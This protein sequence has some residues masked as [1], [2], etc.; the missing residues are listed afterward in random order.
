MMGVGYIGLGSNP[1]EL[2]PEEGHKAVWLVKIEAFAE[3]HKNFNLSR[4]QWSL[5][6]V[7]SALF[8]QVYWRSENVPLIES[9]ALRQCPIGSNERTVRNALTTFPTSGLLPIS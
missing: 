9:S 5:K 4:R 1:F 7:A 3:V 6:H 2:T 8:A